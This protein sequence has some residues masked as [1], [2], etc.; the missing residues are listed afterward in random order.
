MSVTS[1]TPAGVAYCGKE[2]ITSLSTVKSL[3]PPSHARWAILSRSPIRT[4]WPDHQ[5]RR[6]TTRRCLM[7]MIRLTMS[8]PT[9]GK[10]A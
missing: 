2:Q 7:V 10:D 3:A 9:F 1:I 6:P 5:G 4:T 8:A